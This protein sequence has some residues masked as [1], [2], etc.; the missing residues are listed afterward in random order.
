[1]RP[2]RLSSWEP[3]IVYKLCL[4]WSTSEGLLCAAEVHT[5]DTQ[6]DQSASV[7]ASY[8]QGN[9]GMSAA[10][11]S[12]QKRVR[13]PT[14]ETMPSG[15]FLNR[16]SRHSA[17][18]ASTEVKLPSTAPPKI[19]KRPPTLGSA[20]MLHQISG[21]AQVSDVQAVSLLGLC[22]ACHAPLVSW[23]VM[24]A[25]PSI[26]IFRHNGSEMCRHIIAHMRMTSP[27]AQMQHLAGWPHKDPDMLAATRV[28]HNAACMQLQEQQTAM[29]TVPGWGR[30]SGTGLTT[31]GPRVKACNRWVLVKQSHRSCLRA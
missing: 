31:A 4:F 22:S 29:H 7:L 23:F 5:L 13:R 20:C 14:L 24:Q 15:Q 2:E 19:S 1:M 3:A 17:L 26:Q 11:A 16:Q 12:K 27:H 8:L 18:G 28:I 6:Q 30:Q 25:D 21:A 10:Q 9:I